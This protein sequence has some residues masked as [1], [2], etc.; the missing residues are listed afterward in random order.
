M[1]KRIGIIGCGAIGKTLALFVDSELSQYAK[2]TALCD[3]EKPKAEY[4]LKKLKNHNARIVD[5]DRLINL[6]DFVIEA[7][8]PKISYIVAKKSINAGK[9]VLLMSIGG[10]VSKYKEVFSLAQ[11]KKVNIFLPSGA[12]CGLDGLKA[13]SLSKIDSVTLVTTKP[14][15]GLR[16]AP[17]LEYKKI[18]IDKIKDE[19]TIFQGSAQE[20]IRAFPNNVNVAGLLSICGIG[21]KK[22]KVLIKTSPKLDKNTHEVIISSKAGKITTRSENVP[23]KENPK[24]SF[25]AALSAMSVLKN[26]FN[27]VKIGN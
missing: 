2:I 26:I 21:S 27:S 25:L 24:T 15:E 7:A 18:D 19:T 3:K 5:I 20:A 8:S 14:V 10:I 12:I 22:T 4:L 1:K 23:F 6:V 9:D 17:Y 11:R 16:G 13:L